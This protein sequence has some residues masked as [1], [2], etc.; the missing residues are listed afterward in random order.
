[1]SET[2][3]WIGFVVWAAVFIMAVRFMIGRWK[4]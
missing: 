1:M 4:P 3:A 2:T